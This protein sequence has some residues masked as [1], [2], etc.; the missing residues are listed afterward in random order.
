[1]ADNFGN[2]G[3]GKT[4]ES[5]RLKDFLDS[6]AFDKV[7]TSQQFASALE[8]FVE[9]GDEIE[10]LELRSHFRSPDH[11]NACIRLYRK[12]KHFKDTELQELL[13]NHM[14]GYPAIG[15]QRIDILLRAVCGQYTQQK[16]KGFSNQ[17]RGMLG[18][19][20]K[21]ENQQ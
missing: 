19:N 21:N 10:D 20:K 17:L 3:D 14:A 13:M 5:K 9:R 15:G 1:M 7:F 16:E 11:M 12:A 2:N 6:D 8:K 18:L 4:A